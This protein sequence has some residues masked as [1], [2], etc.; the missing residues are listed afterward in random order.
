V[1]MYAKCGNIEIARQVFDTMPHRDVVAWTTMIVGYGING[2]GRE[3]VLLFKQLQ[4]S[5]DLHHS[6]TPTNSSRKY[7][8]GVAAKKS[9]DNNSKGVDIGYAD[10]HFQFNGM[11]PASIPK[12]ISMGLAVGGTTLHRLTDCEPGSV[13][14]HS[15]GFVFLNGMV[16]LDDEEKHHKPTS[17]KR[18]W[19]AIN[20]V[21]GCGFDSSK[22]RVFYT[23][24]GDEVYS[25]ICI[26]DDFSHPLYP[27]IAAM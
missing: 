2:H 19:N 15:T 4:Q 22:R 18:V 11:D 27:T 25:L 12:V 17:T 1:D 21:I 13:G 23:L 26:S 9:S 7:K 3:D 5:G 20:T 14:F 6:V 10:N 24:N 16:H 8:V